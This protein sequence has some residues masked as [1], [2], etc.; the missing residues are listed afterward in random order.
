MRR[1]LLLVLLGT[2]LAGCETAPVQP[3]PTQVRINDID[4][5]LGRVEGVI[6]N[7]SLVSLSQRLD[8]L[9]AQVRQLRGSVEE[10]QN[11]SDGLRKQ[12][13][14]L[15]ADLDKRVGAL[16]AALKA[17]G[18]AG[19]GA[20]GAGAGAAG[21]GADDAGAGTAGAGAAA[22][23]AVAGAGAGGGVAATD[24]AAYAQAFNTLKAGDYSGAI[25]QFG[26]FMTTY[27]GS[28]LLANAQYWLGQAYY[29]SRDYDNAAKAFRAVGERW[30]D[31]RKAPDALLSLG[32]TQSAQQHND[33]ARTTLAQVVQRFPDS[34]AAKLATAQL[35]KLPA[36]A[37]SP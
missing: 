28:S 30:P 1:V 32:L 4:T 2:A 11:G 13:R 37:T 3:D 33:A 14:D 34:D 18:V 8:T 17:G 12:Q 20:A 36:G 15:Y 29:V 10:L 24:Q 35:Q 23:G 21:G 9:E 27:P 22:T 25:R 5:R 16:E 26:D 7:R 6:N 19:G 31:S